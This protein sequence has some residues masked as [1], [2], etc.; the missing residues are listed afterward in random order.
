VGDDWRGRRWLSF[1][2]VEG[3]G[4]IPATV[5]G[6]DLSDLDVDGTAK[7]SNPDRFLDTIGDTLDGSGGRVPAGRNRVDVEVW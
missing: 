2:P 1:E 3:D 4:R 5:A 6:G 7:V